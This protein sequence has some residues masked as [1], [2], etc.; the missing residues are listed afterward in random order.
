[1]DFSSYWLSSRTTAIMFDPRTYLLPEAAGWGQ[2]IRSRVKQN[3]CFPRNQSITVLLYTFVFSTKLYSIFPLT[4]PLLFRRFQYPR[5]SSLRIGTTSWLCGV[6]ITWLI[7]P[8]KIRPW[9][10]SS[11]AGNR[12]LNC[13]TVNRKLLQLL[14]ILLLT[15]KMLCIY[16]IALI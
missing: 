9:V 1:M 4:Y 6:N 5:P 2:Q 3:C 14:V 7:E 10:N 15:A 11:I 13:W 16:C 12:S 8:M